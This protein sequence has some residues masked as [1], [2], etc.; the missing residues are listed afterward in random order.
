MA[1]T[2]PRLSRSLAFGL[3]LLVSAAAG[4]G[5]EVYRWTDAEGREHFAGSLAE[6]PPSE[7]AE[8]QARAERAAPSRFQSFESPSDQPA[9]LRP[10]RRGGVLRIPYEQHGNAML[11]RVRL[12][13]RV[14]APFVVDTGATDVVVPA[15]VAERAGIAIGADTPRQVYATANGHV[16]QPVVVF[17]AVEVGEARVENV[18][19]SVSDSLPVG[20][21]GTSFFNHFTLQIDPAARLLTLVENPDMRGGASESQWTER[22]RVLRERQARLDDFLADG[23]LTDATRR[24]QL[25]ARRDELA[26]ALDALE[27]EANRAGVPAAWRE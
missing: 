9:A 18:R 15:A 27:D 24:R 12:N 13:D 4:A 5:A 2:M 19:G 14:T 17:E 11:V 21:L 22:F 8:A 26:A 6:V 10:A 23:E 7:R 20:L 16:S 3:A 1:W 25:E